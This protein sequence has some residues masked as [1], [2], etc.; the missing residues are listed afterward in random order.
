MI[1]RDNQEGI[2]CLGPCTIRNVWF[3]KVCEDAIT[4]LQG[5]GIS[6]IIGGGARSAVDKVIQHN[7]GG[8]LAISSTTCLTLL[9]TYGHLHNRL[10]IRS[11]H[12]TIDFFVWCTH[13]LRTRIPHRDGQYP[14][15]LCSRLWS[16]VPVM[17]EL[18][19]PGD[20]SSED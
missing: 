14:R 20:A 10:D 11:Y 15:L 9:L 17:W 19:D 1:G 12:L 2:H 16:L 18:Q 7:G 3:E 13:I 6:A 4:L 8:E 5:S